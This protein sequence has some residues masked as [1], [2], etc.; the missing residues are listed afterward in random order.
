METSAT[1][2]QKQAASGSRS[3]YAGPWGRVT[4]GAIGGLACAC[5]YTLLLSEDERTKLDRLT[6]DDLEFARTNCMIPDHPFNCTLEECLRYEHYTNNPLS[7]TNPLQLFTLNPW[8]PE[9][10]RGLIEC[11]KCLGASTTEGIF[12][13]AGDTDDVIA[14]KEEIKASGYKMM[15]DVVRRA[16]FGNAK[17]NGLGALDALKNQ[18]EVYTGPTFGSCVESGDLLKQWLRGLKDPLIPHA[19]YNSALESVNFSSDLKAT[20]ALFNNLMKSNQA[21]ISY[22]VDFWVDL[23]QH[24]D[25]TLM[26]EAALAIVFSPNILKE[27][28]GD[29]SKFALNHEKEK[30]FVLQLIEAGKRGLLKVRN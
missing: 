30:R 15:S 29:P 10:M 27:P 2:A 23:L 24:K 11:T 13:L 8:V 14:L 1:E 21:S 26:D 17:A 12:R 6:V 18:D 5:F 25:V 16:A 9:I 20:V 19:F 3:G 22:L 4:G 7:K 28:S